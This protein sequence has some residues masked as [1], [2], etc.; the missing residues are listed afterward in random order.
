MAEMRV[1]IAGVE[2]VIDPAG[3]LWLPESR[4]LIV[5]DLHLEKALVLRAARH[6]P[7]ALRHAAR[8]CSRSPRWCFAAN[9][10][11]IVSLGDSFHDFGGYGRLTEADRARLAS[12]QRGREWIWV[13]GN[14]DPELPADIG[15]EIVAG[16]SRST[17]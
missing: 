1:T 3:A 8:R 11:R 5:A 2:V 16:A 14:H 4:T 13:S 9:P 10:R 7:A 15:G 6:V 17:A 12:L